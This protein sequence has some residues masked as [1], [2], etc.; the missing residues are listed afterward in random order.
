MFEREMMFFHRALGIPKTGQGRLPVSQ[1]IKYS[2][3]K[4]Y[5]GM[6]KKCYER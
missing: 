4:H 6:F 3:F 2:R 1:Y 5:T